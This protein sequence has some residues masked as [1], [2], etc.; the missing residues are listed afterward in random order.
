MRYKL[1]LMAD[2]LGRYHWVAA[3]A[4]QPTPFRRLLAGVVA[5]AL[6]FGVTQLLLGVFWG[7]GTDAVFFSSFALAVA[8]AVAAATMRRAMAV[9]YGVLGALWLLLEALVLMLGCI[10]AGLG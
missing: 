5:G 2:R 1:G 4:A 9:V 7:A 6:A 3:L 10:A 8:A